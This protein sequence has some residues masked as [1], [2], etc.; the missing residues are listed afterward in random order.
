[1]ITQELLHK[2]FDYDPESGWLIWKVN[3]PPR[4]KAG[5]RAGYLNKHLGYRMLGLMG[6]MYLEHRII[7]FWMEGRWPD[8]EVDHRNWVGD[9]NRWENL[10]EAPIAGNL[11]N[12][13]LYC[14][15]KTGRKGV[16]Q[17]PHNRWYAQITINKKTHRLGTFDTIEEAAAAYDAAAI[18]AFGEFAVTNQMLAEKIN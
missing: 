12:K 5:Q 16:H 4:G 15:N 6:E 13:P 14:N 2:F 9:D 11:S 8:P 1:M 3:K 10:R 18:A 7:F 17:S